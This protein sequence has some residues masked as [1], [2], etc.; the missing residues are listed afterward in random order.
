MLL[1]KIIGGL[2]GLL[3]FGFFGAVLG[4]F[5]GHFFDQGLSIQ[6]KRFD[7]LQKAAMEQAFI[8]VLF[9]L[10]GHLAKSDGRVS[11]D[12]ISA[13]EELIAK[14]GLSGSK[15]QEAISLFQLGVQSD[16]DLDQTVDSFLS[17]IGP[18]KEIKKILLVYLISLAF[19]DGHLHDSEDSLL[20][21]VANKLGYSSFAYNHLLG[22]I[23]AQAHF[24]HKQGGDQA[25]CNGRY[26]VADQGRSD[27]R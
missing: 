24:Y 11:E 5:V 27:H 19:A 7:P 10:M 3:T 18:Y 4:V 23:K 16:F 8:R 13:T 1:G 17:D 9:P 26:A 20:R 25:G 2:I 6:K 21:L 12:E 14:L 22:M 15:R